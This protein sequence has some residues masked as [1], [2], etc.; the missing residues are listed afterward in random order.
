M[1]HGVV[2]LYFWQIHHILLCPGVPVDE[3]VQTALYLWLLDLFLWLRL[4]TQSAALTLQNVTTWSIRDA[5][6]WHVSISAHVSF[7]KSFAQ[8]W[9]KNCIRLWRGALNISDRCARA[10]WQEGGFNRFYNRE[11]YSQKKQFF[12]IHRQYLTSLHWS[13]V[14]L[15][16]H[17]NA[18]ITV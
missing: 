3:I 9:S 12:M 18:M 17:C 5:P 8:S 13:L 4:S 14:Q 10:E 7:A 1:G 11:K 15:M 6:K 16:V 2:M